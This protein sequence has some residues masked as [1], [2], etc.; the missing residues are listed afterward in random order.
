M[1]F[2]SAIEALI[3]PR[4]EWGKEKVTKRFIKGV[5]SLCPQAVDNLIA[6][7]NI[8]MALQLRLKGSPS[9]RRYDVLDGIYAMRSV[10][11]HMGIGLSRNAML[12]ALGSSENMRVALLSDLARAAILGFLQAPRSFLIGHPLLDPPAE[13]PTTR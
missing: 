5:R 8:E 13:P 7:P 4:L 11:T 9:R 10:P 12:L 6:H 2:V 1:L 3:A